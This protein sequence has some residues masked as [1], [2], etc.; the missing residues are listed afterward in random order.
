MLSD[1]DYFIEVANRIASSAE[2]STL[3]KEVI[4]PYLTRMYGI[5]AQGEEGEIALLQ[6]LAEVEQDIAEKGNDALDFIEEGVNEAQD[7]FLQ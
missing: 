7:S 3:R 2:P 5:T 1:P 4:L 6:I